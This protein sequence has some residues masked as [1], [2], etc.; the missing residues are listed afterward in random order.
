DRPGHRAADDLAQLIRAERGG[1]A[2][3]VCP[4]AEMP[5]QV[6][7]AAHVRAPPGGACPHGGA[8]ECS[9]SI[10]SVTAD[11][12]FGMPSSAARLSAIASRRRMRPATASLVIGGSAS[13]SSSTDDQG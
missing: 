6:E 12:V 2:P 9:S 13:W 5:G 10:S 11:S 3:L 1:A 4:R 7:P 8:Y